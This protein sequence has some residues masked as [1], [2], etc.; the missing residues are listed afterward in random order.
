MLSQA[1]PG[2][3]RQGGQLGSPVEK[4][5]EDGEQRRHGGRDQRCG[6]STLHGVFLERSGE[7]IQEVSENSTKA[8][9][10][11]ARACVRERDLWVE[12]VAGIRAPPVLLHLQPLALKGFVM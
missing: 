1:K 10:A 8:R 12:R 5:E 4:N 6:A 9:R 3:R 2:Q 11:C 7:H